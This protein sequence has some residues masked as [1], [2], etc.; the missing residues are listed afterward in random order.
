M[1]SKSLLFSLVYGCVVLSVSAGPGAAVDPNLLPPPSTKT[2]LTYAADIQPIF[3]Q[4][5]YPC[6]SHKAQKPK[7]KLLL[8]SLAAV[9]KGGEDGPILVP[10]KSAKSALVIQVSHQGDPDGYMPP[11]KN[12]ANVGPLTKEQIGLIRAWIDQGAK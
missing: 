7:G 3:A 1:L 4:S 11:P 10:G 5:C 8:D 2:G 12:K 9:L 6:H